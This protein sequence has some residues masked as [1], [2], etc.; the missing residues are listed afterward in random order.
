MSMPLRVFLVYFKPECR[1]HA[2]AEYELVAMPAADVADA[3]AFLDSGR[4][5]RGTRL[6]GWPA[7][8]DATVRLIDRV[9][10][11]HF[12]REHVLDVRQ[13]HLTCM[14]RSGAASAPEEAA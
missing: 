14:F 12:S 2:A 9:F 1:P 6:V 3:K 4:T 7:P 11:I 5:V 13:S 10:L 8:N